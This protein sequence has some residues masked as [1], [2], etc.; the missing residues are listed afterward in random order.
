MRIAFFIFTLVWVFA[1]T[2][3]AQTITNKP[4]EIT[5]AADLAAQ[6]DTAVNFVK[7]GQW[8]GIVMLF[9]QLAIFIMKKISVVKPWFKKWG[10]GIVLILSAG[11]SFCALMV[12]GIRWYEALL[13]FAVGPLMNYLDKLWNWIEELRGKREP[14]KKVV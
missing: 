13:V 7:T 12:A 4:P 1:F 11:A 3:A 9:L 2:V 5:S 8:A 6:T 10:P 14:S